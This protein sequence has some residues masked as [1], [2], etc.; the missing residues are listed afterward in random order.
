[1]PDPRHNII[2]RISMTPYMVTRDTG[3]AVTELRFT[4]RFAPFNQGLPYH[5]VITDT[6]PPISDVTVTVDVRAMLQSE[7]RLL[8]LRINDQSI[9]QWFRDGGQNCPDNLQRAAVTIS[10]AEWERLRTLADP[11]TPD[12]LDLNLLGRYTGQALCNDDEG[13]DAT[14]AILTVEY[15][16]ERIVE[17]FRPYIGWVSGHKT[18]VASEAEQGE[19][20]GR[21][22]WHYGEWA[23]CRRTRKLLMVSKSHQDKVTLGGGGAA[24][25]DDDGQQIPTRPEPGAF[26]CVSTGEVPGVAARIHAVGGCDLG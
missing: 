26:E 1:V 19:S 5:F 4:E 2:T 24:P 20:L 22:H 11:W 15:N 13:F 6:R 14:E 3:E 16:V 21:P 23:V 25:A 8:V 9:A 18:L 7:S 12:V 10:A 17:D